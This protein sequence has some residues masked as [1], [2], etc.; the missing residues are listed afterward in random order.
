MSPFQ[1]RDLSSAALFSVRGKVAV[2]TGGGTGIGASMAL[3]LDANG[4]KS[5]YILGRRLEVLEETAQKAKNGSIRP[6]VA[7][8]GSKESL[9]QARE[10]ITQQEGLVDVLIA[11]SGVTGPNGGFDKLYA[12]GQQPSLAEL[13]QCVGAIDM[14]EFTSTFHVNVT[15]AFFSAIAFLP[16]LEAAN[17]TRPPFAPRAQIIVTSSISA[18]NRA[19]YLGFAYIRCNVIAPGFF[20]SEMTEGRWGNGKD[21]TIEG[22]VSGTD[23]PLERTGKEDDIAGMVL[24]L[25]SAAGAYVDGCVHLLDGGRVAVGNSTY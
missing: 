24:F 7:D 16:L 13:Q 3:T 8:V 9:I 18:F 19:P 2:I 20:V 17:Q 10:H 4:A 6:V 12:D 15:G 22:N 1:S 21:P 14:A 23:V 25:C 5:V 11:N